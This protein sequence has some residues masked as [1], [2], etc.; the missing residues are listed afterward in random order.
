M[1]ATIS[2]WNILRFVVQSCFELVG[3]SF[4]M[5]YMYS[6]SFHSPLKANVP[7][8]CPNSWER[9]G[10]KFMEQKLCFTS[11]QRRGEQTPVLGTRTYHTSGAHIQLKGFVALI[12][13][14]PSPSIVCVVSFQSSDVPCMFSS[15][16]V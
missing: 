3:R 16:A 13:S 2:L 15:N 11:K 1:I 12:G 4:H 6:K 9:E 14:C 5:N 8:Q 7:S 10:R